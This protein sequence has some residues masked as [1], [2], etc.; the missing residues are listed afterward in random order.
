MKKCN[1]LF[2]VKV[3]FLTLTL[4]ILSSSA[5]YAQ[6]DSSMCNEWQFQMAPYFLMAGLNGTAGIRG[7]TS[8]VDMSF[9][10]IFNK[11]NFA[12]MMAVE[13]RKGRWGIILDG[14]YMKLKDQKTKSWTGPAGV[15]T[16]DGSLNATM[17]QQIYEA[18]L[19]YRFA[20]GRTNLDFIAGMR[21]TKIDLELA[22]AITTNIPLLPD[23]SVSVSGDRDWLDPVIGARVYHSFSPAFSFTV[24]QDFG[25]FGISSDLTYQFVGL[26]NW[27]FFDGLSAKLGYRFLYQNYQKDD[28]KWNTN[29]SGPIWGIG[30]R[31]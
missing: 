11:L 20:L 6:Q 1:S 19:N 12:F 25:G 8:D 7:V 15:V 21:Y 2:I 26:I 13:V 22:L 28:F 30:F 14:I 3:I 9:S 31:F 23:S 29:V 18:L 10:D 27:T 5:I 4:E 16:I 24:Y 17:T